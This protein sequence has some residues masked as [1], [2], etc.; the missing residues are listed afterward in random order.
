METVF[1]P[2]FIEKKRTWNF[3]SSKYRV[4]MKDSEDGSMRT[5]MSCVEKPEMPCGYS[6]PCGEIEIPDPKDD[7]RG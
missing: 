3:Y 4:L 1:L 5:Y 7:I 2:D 6:W